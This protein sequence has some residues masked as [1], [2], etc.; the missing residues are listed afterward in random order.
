[1]L[2]PNPKNNQ[3]NRQT[4]PPLK[5]E[6]CQI[7]MKIG[8]VTNSSTRIPKIMVLKLKNK[9]KMDKNPPK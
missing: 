9:G 5:K 3:T 6:S 8:T 7:K 1:M 2:V 4:T